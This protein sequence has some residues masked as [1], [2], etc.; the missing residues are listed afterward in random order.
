MPPVHCC[1]SGWLVLH[2][3]LVRT[4]FLPRHCAVLR[5]TLLLLLKEPGGGRSHP[6]SSPAAAA[7]PTGAAARDHAEPPAAPPSPWPPPSRETRPRRVSLL[8][9]RRLRRSLDKQAE[10]TGSCS[11]GWGTFLPVVF[12][13]VAF[14]CA[15]LLF[16][17]GNIRNC[18]A[19]CTAEV[20]SVTFVVVLVCLLLL[21]SLFVVCQHSVGTH[22]AHSTNQILKG[23]EHTKLSSL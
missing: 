14:Q 16:V 3:N 9:F 11:R 7:P 6:P 17:F 21:S 22:S 20:S 5:L 15:S 13:Q 8:I 1:N 18:N 12:V 4:C 23:E 2:E 10:S 19:V